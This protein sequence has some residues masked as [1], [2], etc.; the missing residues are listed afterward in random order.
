MEVQVELT[1]SNV[2]RVPGQR[3]VVVSV[4]ESQDDL[5][6]PKGCLE[7]SRVYAG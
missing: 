3:M 2:V 7:R 1:C 4:D 6:L 5:N